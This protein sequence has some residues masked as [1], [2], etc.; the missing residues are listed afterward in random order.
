MNP[1]LP[2][3]PPYSMSFSIDLFCPA[4]ASRPLPVDAA[5]SAALSLELAVRSPAAARQENTGL[6]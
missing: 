3:R 1:S 4:H 5:R 2:D 6:P